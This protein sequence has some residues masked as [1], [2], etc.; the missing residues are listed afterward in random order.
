[1][2]L[3]D[4]PSSWIFTFDEN[5]EVEA[6]D[7]ESVEVPEDLTNVSD[8][9]LDSLETELLT[10]FDAIR[11]GT[12]QLSSD[13]IQELRTIAAAVERVR[14]EKSKR[15]ENRA[16]LSAEADELAALVRPD[17]VPPATTT[18][19]VETP[20][21]PAAPIEASATEVTP[22]TAPPAAQVPPTPVPAETPA[23]PVAAATQ[24]A[25]AGPIVI[26]RPRLNVPL[27]EVQRRAP[28]PDLSPRRE[29]MVVTAPD[30]PNYVA[31]RAL[32]DLDVLADAVHRRARTLASP[33][34]QITVASIRREFDITLDV[35]AAPRH[36]WDIMKKAA[37]PK[38]L[39]AAG[40]W[41]APS[42]IIYDFFNIACDDGILDVPTIGIT[43]GGIRFPTSPSIADALGSIWLWTEADDIAAAVSATGGP[44]P[45]K[46]CVRVPCPSFNEE[47]L[48]CHGLCLTAGNLTE[49]A[50]P[51][52]I[53][54]F[55]S[56]LM[57]AHRHVINQRIIADIVANST[58]V[59]VTGSD[60]PIT[61]GLLGAIDLQVA[62]YRERYRMCDNDPLEVVLPRWAKN[63]IRSDIAKRTGV[64]MLAVTDAEIMSWFDLRMVRV[65]FVS[66]WQVGSSDF[67]GQATPRQTWPA[68]VQFLIFAA[69]TFVV[70]NGLDLDL[71]VVRDSVLNATNDHTAAWTE[72]CKLVAKIGHDSRLVTVDFCVS[73]RTGAADIGLAGLC[74]IV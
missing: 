69:G 56:L 32:E 41:C 20:A 50:Y 57:N 31:G 37:D 54:N 14:A 3:Q 15:A 66:D 42:T 43:R 73:G 19:T 33:S 29:A 44:G 58:A 6:E 45:K 67:P 65:Q 52:L 30:V 23:Q 70:G 5:T 2:G 17:E 55:L 71:G 27:S 25:P 28:D 51:E 35:E 47:R 72:E 8:T 10:T 49:S 1:M 62:D 61:T 64:N 13:N 26:R 60:A 21:A 39:V 36:I 16:Q 12:E 24:T 38:H 46:P 18:E 9:D 74:N 40:G 59:S 22:E 63:A 68:A 4:R 11:A 34:G 53:R 48:D 7:E